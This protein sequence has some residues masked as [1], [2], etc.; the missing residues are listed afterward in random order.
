M[1]DTQLVSLEE[2]V[3]QITSAM[4]T[5][6][7]DVVSLDVQ[8]R[9]VQIIEDKLTADCD[10]TD[11]PTIHHFTDNPQTE[12]NTYCREFHVPAGTML[13]GVTYNSEVFWVL[14]QGSMRLIE[15]DGYRDIHAPCLLK[16]VVGIKNCGYA[17]SDCLFFG[18]LPNLTNSRDI[19]DLGASITDT[20]A[21]QLLGMPNNKQLINTLD[22]K[23]LTHEVA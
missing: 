18:F 9:K 11:C 17:Y 1:E 21:D 16:N 8:R 23:A 20:P 19:A 12:Y 14:A 15:G 5:R 6:A 22:R 7:A 13:T 10:Q 2:E 4:V 3:Q